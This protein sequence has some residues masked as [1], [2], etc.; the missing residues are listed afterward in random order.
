MRLDDDGAPLLGLGA[1]AEQA[2]ARLGQAE[3]GL[4]ERRAEVGELNEVG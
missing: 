4:R 1:D 3:D 2:D